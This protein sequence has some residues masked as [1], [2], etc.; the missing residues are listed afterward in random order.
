M[1]E[2]NIT[3][4]RPAADTGRAAALMAALAKAQGAFP[5]I[6]KNRT[7]TIPTKTGN[8]YQFRYAD[9]EEILSKTRPALAANGLSLI[10]QMELIQGG[11]LLTCSLMHAEGHRIVSEVLLPSSRDVGDPKTFGAS[12]SYYRRY[13]ITAMLGVAAD[14]DLDEDG[15]E[16]RPAQRNVG[17]KP[18]VA[19][20]Q[21]RQESA[22][23]SSEHTGVNIQAIKQSLLDAPNPE[24]LQANF[25]AAWL[26]LDKAQREAVKAVYDER[27]AAFEAGAAS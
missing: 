22:P 23:A 8:S 24:A 16:A 11:M 15:Q 2:T 17:Q 26:M 12:I 20:P 3:E 7:V 1:E 25:K 21:R 6:E 14:D 4:A 9:L 18:A 19:T 13:M 10:Q 27:K 5:P